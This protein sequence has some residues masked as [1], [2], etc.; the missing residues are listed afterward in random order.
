METTK[1]VALVTGGMG[2]LGEAICIKL[3]ALGDTVVTTYSPANTKAQQWLESM[4]EQGF[5]FHA[6]PCDVTDWDSCHACI[7]QVTHDLG[8]GRRAGEQRRHHPRHDVQENG[9]DQLGRGDARE[10]RLVLQHDQAGVRGHGGSGLGSRD[11]HLVG[12]WSEGCIRPNQL[13]RRQSRYARLY[14]S[15]RLGSGPQGCHRQYD[16]TRLYRYE[17]GD[18]DSARRCSIRRSFRRFPWVGS[19]NPKKWPDWWRISPARRPRFLTGANIAI[20][21]GQHMQ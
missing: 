7:A 6:Y 13:F 21:G 17:N 10:P 2:G 20:N 8:T 16:F 18:G 3:A 1:R 14:E 12:Q 11:Q 4:K 5:H 9:Q 15:A 19:A